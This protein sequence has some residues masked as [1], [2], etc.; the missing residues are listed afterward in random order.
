MKERGGVC[1]R[2]WRGKRR[3]DDITSKVKGQRF[4]K[5]T[6]LELETLL[7]VLLALRLLGTGN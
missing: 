3:G 2:V 5:F 6:T 7:L 4:K 1:G